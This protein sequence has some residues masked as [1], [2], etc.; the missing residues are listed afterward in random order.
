[1]AATVRDLAGEL[2]A[3]ALICLDGGYSLAALS[4]SLVATLEA[5]GAGREPRVAAGG[6]ADEYRQRLRRLWPALDGSA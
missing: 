3:P 1:M 5:F 4:G 2:E 6:P